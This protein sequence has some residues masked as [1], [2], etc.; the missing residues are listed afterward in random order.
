MAGGFG[1]KSNP[2]S[3]VVKK[4][5]SEILESFSDTSRSKPKIRVFGQL[6]PGQSFH[7]NQ[8][9]QS[10]KEDINWNREFLAKTINEEQHLFVNQHNQEIQQT[11]N[12]ILDEIKKLKLSVDNLDHEVIQA[13]EQNIP[14]HEY[15][16]SSFKEF[17]NLIIQFRQNIDQSC[18]GWNF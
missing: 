16:L 9:A 2:K 18:V 7:P 1:L 10:K 14:S 8:E 3:K 12:Q 5:N 11:I 17:K 15:Q 13:S 4:N 6:F